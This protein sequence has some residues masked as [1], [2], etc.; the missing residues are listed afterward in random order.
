MGPENIRFGGGASATILHPGVAVA[1]VLAVILILVL[2]RQYILIPALIA[3]FLIP[4]EQQILL[5]GVHLNV[6]RILIL[7]GL[8]RWTFSG[9]WS[10][11][12]GGFTSLD[13]ACVALFVCYFMTVTLLYMDAQAVIKNAGDLLDGLGGYI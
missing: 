8:A 1:M 5:A 4:K 11:L 13:G 7:A 6:Y 9:R 10:K 3:L 12:A 2:R